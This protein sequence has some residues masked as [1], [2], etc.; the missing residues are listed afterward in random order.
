MRRFI[1]AANKT[2]IFGWYRLVDEDKAK[3]KFVKTSR[4][5]YVLVDFFFKQCFYK[6]RAYPFLH[7][8]T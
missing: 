4:V 8:H 2:A 7:L 5:L 6:V 3:F 1:F